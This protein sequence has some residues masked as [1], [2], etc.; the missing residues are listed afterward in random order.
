MKFS[1]GDVRKESVRLKVPTDGGL[2]VGQFVRVGVEQS[3]EFVCP[4]LPLCLHGAGG[5][6]TGSFD[7]TQPAGARGRGGGARPTGARRR[8][9]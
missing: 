7:D 6:R 2:E 4:R 9:G 5:G 8:E 3:L 1:L